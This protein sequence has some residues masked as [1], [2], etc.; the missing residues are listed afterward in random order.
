M[1][2][3]EQMGP[4]YNAPAHYKLNNNSCLRGKLFLV[5]SIPKKRFTPKFLFTVV[6]SNSRVTSENS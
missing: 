5:T 3:N 1:T 4:G 6:L 2:Q